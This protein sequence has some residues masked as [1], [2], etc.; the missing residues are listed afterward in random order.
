LR[1]FVRGAQ[2]SSMRTLFLVALGSALGGAA[3][4]LLAGWVGARLG[5]SFPWG[6]VLVNV[7]GSALIGALAAQEEM[8]SPE[9]RQFLMVGVLGGFT[10]FSSFSLQTL[11]LAQDG[12]WV[13]ATGNVLGSVALCLAAVA[14]GYRVARLA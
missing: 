9:A 4:F 8:L 12:D 13:R 2:A 3:R 5:E 7:L 6:T 14:V 11:R 10:T 1:V